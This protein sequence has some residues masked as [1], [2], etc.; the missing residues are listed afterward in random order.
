MIVPEP[1]AALLRAVP[2]A[3]TLL[4]ALLA[5]VVVLLALVHPS[6]AGF[7]ACLVMALLSD[8]FDGIIARR[9]GIA[10]PTLRRLDSIADTIF[11]VGMLFA[12]W[13][14]YPEAILEHLFGL[15]LLIVLELARYAHDI[16][17]FGRE[18][19]Y[20]MWSSKIWGITLFVAFFALLVLGIAGWPVAVAIYV[21]I[22][23]D[24]EG[25][26]ISVILGRWRTDVPT[27]VHALRLQHREVHP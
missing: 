5:P 11:Y 9:L 8:L 20:H 21:G 1:G 19:S 6:R 26:A 13:H 10:T 18:A 24:A 7:G 15:L 2:L 27:F 4:R 23:A 17:K 16:A 12:A 3:L 25:L 22:I 14:L